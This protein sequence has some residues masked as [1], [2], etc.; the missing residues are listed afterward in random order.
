MNY[1]PIAPV[2]KLTGRD[3]VA[4]V[5]PDAAFRHLRFLRVFGMR[6][7]FREPATYSEKLN[8]RILYDRRDVLSWTC[9]KLAMKDYANAIEGLE[10][11]VPEVL[12]TGTDVR[13]LARVE[14]TGD[15]VLKPNHASGRNIVFGSGPVT[16]TRDL[17]SYM[18]GA[19][20][21]QQASIL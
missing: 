1:W 9:D 13:H 17:E 20:D 21:E 14:L 19:M 16:D 6:G 7:N 10:I 15:W 12:W 3:R 11:Q 2:V 5:L 8:W 4:R 18:A